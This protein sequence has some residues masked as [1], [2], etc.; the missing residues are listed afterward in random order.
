MPTKLTTLNEGLSTLQFQ[1]AVP[2]PSSP[3]TLIGGT[4]DN[5]TWLGNAGDSA[6]NQ[7]IYG[8][9]GVAALRRLEQERHDERV[10]RRRRRT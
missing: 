3:G 4:Q 10:L 7:T 6:W 1:N 5:G 8:D 2:N 9:G